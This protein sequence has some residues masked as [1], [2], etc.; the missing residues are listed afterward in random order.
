MFILPYL[1]AGCRLFCYCVDRSERGAPVR[2]ALQVVLITTRRVGTC[3]AIVWT[4]WSAALQLVLRSK[5]SIFF[6][7]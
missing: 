4:D 6:L 2:P 5:W 7:R 1:E 3:S